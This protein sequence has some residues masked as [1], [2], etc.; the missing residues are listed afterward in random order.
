MTGSSHQTHS[1]A[2]TKTPIQQPEPRLAYN[3]QHSN[4]NLTWMKQWVQQLPKSQPTK[5]FGDFR[6]DVTAIMNSMAA[7][8]TQAT[9]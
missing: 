9:R 2:S 1:S 4:L 3:T 6:L 5:E 8:E 7:V